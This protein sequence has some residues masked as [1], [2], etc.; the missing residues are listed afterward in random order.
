M[1]EFMDKY[2]SEICNHCKK[3]F[4]NELA[5]SKG[6]LCYGE[7]CDQ[8][9]ESYCE[10]NVGSVNYLRY[11]RKIKLENLKNVVSER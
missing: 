9:L 7:Y 2:K 4:T 8:A 6:D 5:W 1:E 11:Q 3:Y 10:T